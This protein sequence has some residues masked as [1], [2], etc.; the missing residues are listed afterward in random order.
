M[1]FARSKTDKEYH[2]ALQSFAESEPVNGEESEDGL[3]IVK[4]SRKGLDLSQYIEGRA[5]LK[6]SSSMLLT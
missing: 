1:S 5:S 2:R 6:I 4:T 3:D